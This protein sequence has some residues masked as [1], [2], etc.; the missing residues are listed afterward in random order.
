MCL[1]QVRVLICAGIVL[2]L[3][4]GGSAQPLDAQNISAT[5]TFPGDGEQS[6]SMLI[7]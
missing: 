3:T 1:W 4:L 2:S 7:R 5:R 6:S